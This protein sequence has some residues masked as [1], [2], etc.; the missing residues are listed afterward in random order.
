MKKL[1]SLLAVIGII[2][3]SNCTKIPLNNDPILGT[4]SKISTTTLSD[5]SDVIINE[6]WIFNDAYLGRHHRFENNEPTVVT[7][8]SWSKENNIY[9]IEY[10]A[11]EREPDRV[12]IVNDTHTS[13]LN[14]TQGSI[15]AER[16]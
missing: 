3:I 1:F 5:R 16:E 9:T 12:M 15:F 11:L 14:T 2:T 7:D 10:P 8:F 13:I 6:E 4:W